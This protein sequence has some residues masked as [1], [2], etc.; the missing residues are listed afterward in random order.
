L[1]PY[2][3]AVVRLDDFDFILPKDLIAQRPA[4]ERA[5]SRLLCVDGRTGNIADRQFRELPQLIGANDVV[6]FND[7]R[8]INARLF[9][10]K[11]TGG[12]VEILIERLLDGCSA[13][14][15]LRASKPPRVGSSIQLF[16]GT[17][18]RVLG[19]EG[20]F[21]RLQF[22]SGLDLPAYLERHGSVPLPPYI[23]H[24]PNAEDTSRYQTV[25]SRHP[26]AVAAPTAGL[27]FDETMLAEL[28]QRGIATAYITLHV[29][30][31]TFQPV[32]VNDVRNHAMHGE[33]FNVPLETV[34][35]IERARARKGRVLAVGTTTLRALESAAAGGELRAGLGE[36][37]LF[38]LP[39]YRFRVVER[40]LTNFHLPRSTLL[41]LVSAFGGMEHIR[42]A[43][44]HA[45]SERYR[46]FSY[47]DAM[48]IERHDLAVADMR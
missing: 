3:P 21:Y 15:Q 12:Q 14:V 44:R 16:G 34:T 6:V 36:T 41:M 4:H 8:V 47:G 23:E 20:E 33:W 29:G 13:L 45:V 30:A 24:A 37:N 7:T 32:R 22:E 48:L 19:R 28:R 2:N 35:A 26:G 42:R 46:F 31:G 17:T 27:H 10:T 18:T 11:T 40:L 9:G 43:Y 25:Y 5:A 38:I 39:G 1:L